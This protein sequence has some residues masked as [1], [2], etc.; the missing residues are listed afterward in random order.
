MDTPL[1]TNIINS[2]VATG[3][4]VVAIVAIVAIFQNRSQAREDWK[5]SQQ[6]A[7]DERQHQSRPIIVPIG[8]FEPVSPYMARGNTPYRGDGLVNWAYPDPIQLELQNMG[9]GVALN[10]HCVLYGSEPIHISQFISWDNGPIGKSPIHI[11]YEHPKQFFLNPDDSIDESHPL[12]DTS[13]NSPSNSTEYRIACL[14][15][16]YQDLFDNKYMSIFNH[17]LDHQWLKVKI[18]K[19]PSLKKQLPLDLKELNERKRQQA[20]KFS[21]PAP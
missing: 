11:K 1:A 12:F 5:H 17:T 4:L 15:I 21:A 13:P 10:V 6:L 19:I 20:P 3:T 2:V 18:D 8:E 16:T 7:S 9:E 14:T